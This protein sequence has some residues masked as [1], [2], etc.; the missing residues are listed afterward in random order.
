MLESTNLL[1]HKI[2]VKII[3]DY[4]VVAALNVYLN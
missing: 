1:F 2:F 3:I 4:Y